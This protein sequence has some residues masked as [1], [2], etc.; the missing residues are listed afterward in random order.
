M[1]TVLHSR[2]GLTAVPSVVV[3]LDGV[4]EKYIM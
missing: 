3:L 1:W 2:S 4:T